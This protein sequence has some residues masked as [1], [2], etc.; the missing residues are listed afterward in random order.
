MTS[1]SNIQAQEVKD[2]NISVEIKPKI[3]KNE[4]KEHKRENETNK[5]NNLL[6]DHSK[7]EDVKDK[8]DNFLQF[9][10]ELE[11]ILQEGRLIASKV[12]GVEK[13]E[14]EI[15]LKEIEAT[16]QEPKLLTQEIVASYKDK[17]H[18]LKKKSEASSE[19]E[20]KLNKAKELKEEIGSISSSI[21]YAYEPQEE[22]ILKEA[23]TM[24]ASTKTVE[25]ID[26][27]IA[28]LKQL[29]NKVANRMTR[30]HSGKR[31]S[32]N[33]KVIE[34]S[35]ESTFRGIRFTP[36]ENVQ[37]G[38]VVSNAD[39]NLTYFN[40]DSFWIKTQVT[41]E[42]FRHDSANTYYLVKKVTLSGK[43]FKDLSVIVS[44]GKGDR[45]AS[46]MVDNI[47][48]PN[49]QA[50]VLGNLGTNGIIKP[51]NYQV[52]LTVN[53]TVSPGNNYNIIY[54]ITIKPQ[55]ERN[56]VNNLTPTY[57]DDVR[58]LTENEKTALIEKFKTEHPDV[59]NRAQHIDFERAEVSADG[60]TMTIHFKDGFNPKTIQTNA[61]N[62][63]E[64]KHSSLTA[65]FG[66]NK[67]LYTNPR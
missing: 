49:I 41:G 38:K 4:E 10:Q 12:Q 25:E 33:G 9:Q 27:F 47:N 56:T 65:Y 44:T 14:L 57:V 52:V 55:S 24:T 35:G 46:T 34:N 36:L 32:R 30:E 64:A 15:T 61:T 16:I 31:D 67:E 39:T 17:I 22:E 54:N 40:S 21:Q 63:V 43:P 28:K 23:E 48:N 66:D 60:T 62:D 13:N 42:K 1:I 2:S 18:T 19:L 5:E 51:G 53:D 20:S 50:A 8:K 11:A 6:D 3:D 45:L 37:N 7:Q 29:R 26:A 58:H 59:V